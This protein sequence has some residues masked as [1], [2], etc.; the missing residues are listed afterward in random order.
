V[1]LLEADIISVEGDWDKAME[2]IDEVIKTADP[3]DAVPTVIKAN[4]LTQKVRQAVRE[5]TNTR[6]YIFTT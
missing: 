6:T 1:R 5:S 2:L 3:G 4:I